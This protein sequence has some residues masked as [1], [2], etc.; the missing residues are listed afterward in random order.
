MR[1]KAM[2][3]THIEVERKKDAPKLHPE[4]EEADEAHPKIEGVGEEHPWSAVI[5]IVGILKP[6]P[7]KVGHA[8]IAFVARGYSS[9][10]RHYAPLKFA[11]VAQIL[12]G[13]STLDR[14]SCDK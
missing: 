12:I 13:L 6:S 3:G 10:S 5:M 9:S 7:P 4:V 1:T 8:L 14:L 11:K 2:M